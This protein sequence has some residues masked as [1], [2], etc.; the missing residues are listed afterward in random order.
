MARAV[1]QLISRERKGRTVKKGETRNEL[2]AARNRGGRFILYAFLFSVFVNLLMLTG[3]LFM[4]Q[5]YDRVLASRSEET[6]TALFVLVAALFALMI[7]LDFARTRIL[8][9]FGAQFQSDLD[10][11][12]FRMAFERREGVGRHPV[13]AQQDLEAVQ[14]AFTSPA[15]IALL[16]MPFTPLFLAAIFLFHPYLGWLAIAGGAVLVMLSVGNQLLTR[17]RSGQAQQ[18]HREAQDFSENAYA[19]AEV[20]RAQGMLDV[21]SQRWME[22]RLRSLR[23]TV[24]ARDWTGMFTA[25]TKGMR[26]FLQS[27][28]LALGAWLVLQNELTPGAMIA[29]SILLGR[30]LA[31]VEQS[32]G[33]WPAV[34]RARQGWRSLSEILS[35]TPVQPARMPLPVPK[36]DISV[37]RLGYMPRGLSEPVLSG[38]TFQVEPGQALGVIGRSGSGKS[39]LAKMMLGLARPSTGEV[40]LDGAT[41]D[42]YSSEELGR[43][44]GY[45]PQEPFLFDGTV[46]ENIARMAIEPDSRAVV[47]AAQ[48]AK[49]HDIITNLPEGYNTVIGMRDDRLS[50]GQRQRI[51]LARALFED[52]QLLVLDEPNSALDSEGTEALNRAV[53]GFKEAGKAV[54]IMTHRPM[55]IAECDKLMVMDK[56]RVTALG[57]RDEILRSMVQNADDV[58]KTLRPRS[59]S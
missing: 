4:L 52:P 14:N 13:A 24:G 30:A 9:R 11:R 50:G 46:A 7:V 16:D 36:A 40:R 54:I 5:V 37:Q 38:I 8:A 35:A 31:P 55:A 57:P 34:Q 44:I 32:L 1:H 58:Q 53:R 15:F 39:T 2:R 33:Q 3:P 25:A 56:G 23:E 26:L 22:K 42:Q 51:A 27:A 21:V 12:V 43:H 47:E 49:V 29:G 19:G 17:T 6:L 59:A 20:V 10:E 45:L 48:R 41:I 18:V 28:M